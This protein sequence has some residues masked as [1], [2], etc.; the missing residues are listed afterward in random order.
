ML[1]LLAPI[2]TGMWTTQ[3]KEAL[4]RPLEGSQMDPEVNWGPVRGVGTGL[5]PL[6]TLMKW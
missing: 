6:W 5:H 3:V 1:L 4:N 2:S